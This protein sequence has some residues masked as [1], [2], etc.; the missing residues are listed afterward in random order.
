[1][2]F[3]GFGFQVA[4]I[5]FD[6]VPGARPLMRGVF[7]VIGIAVD[8][9]VL[10]FRREILKW[11]I[12][13]NLAL[14]ANAQ[15]IVLGFAA[16]FGL[17]RFDRAFCDGERAIWNREMVIDA[18]NAAETFAGRACADGVVETEKSR[19]G[20]AIFDVAVRADRKSTRL[21]SSHV[22]LP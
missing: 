17:P 3:V 16:G 8:D 15:Q 11:N 10:N 1:M 19:R 13:W 21:N 12:G 20:F 5:T 14:F 4:E 22:A 9:E 7:A 6:T 2:H 18:D